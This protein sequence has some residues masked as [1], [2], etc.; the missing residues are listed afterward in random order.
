MKKSVKHPLKRKVRTEER[1]EVSRWVPVVQDIIEVSEGHVG[2]HDVHVG[3]HDVHVGAHDVHVGAHDVHMGCKYQVERTHC[4]GR[5][6]ENER[7]LSVFCAV[8]SSFWF[9]YVILPIP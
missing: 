9:G 1:Y 4:Q 5:L 8:C 2:A 3:A 7:V 6:T